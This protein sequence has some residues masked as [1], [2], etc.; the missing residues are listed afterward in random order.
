MGFLVVECVV[1]DCCY[2]AFGVGALDDFCCHNARNRRVFGEVFKV[3]AA[4]GVAVDVS[5][6]CIPGVRAHICCFLACALTHFVGEVCV[7]RAG[8]SRSA[9]VSRTAVGVDKAVSALY[10][11]GTVVIHCVRYAEPF[12]AVC[13]V[14]AVDYKHSHFVESELVEEGIPK[15]FVLCNILQGDC[16]VVFYAHFRGFAFGS[17]FGNLVN[18]NNIIVFV[19]FT[20]LGICGGNI[21]P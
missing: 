2:K 15:A 6:R 3:S 13:F 7:P 20:K 19:Q 1:L 10:A 8:Y 14:T 18:V 9:G 4:S 17:G 12:N 16:L 11:G 5:T 21:C